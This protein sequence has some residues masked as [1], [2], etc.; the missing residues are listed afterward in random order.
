MKGDWKAAKI[1]INNQE[2]IVIATI[3]NNLE[4]AL[5]I[6]VAAKHKRFVKK[7]LKRM[8]SEDLA[9]QNKHG[10]TAL[11][12]AAASGVIEIAKMLID[13][14]PNLPMIR[15]GGEMTP[16]H[17]AALFGN[18]EMVK[19]LYWKT[20]F[21]NL[22]HLEFINLFLSVISADIYGTYL[23]FCYSLSINFSYVLIQTQL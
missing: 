10:N 15:N 9:L 2:N 13:K 14:N 12:F 11:C 23:N 17:V 6:A 1:I 19:Y 22:S 7:L 4:I 20:D 3:T 8:S 18:G 5:H 16:I 21:S